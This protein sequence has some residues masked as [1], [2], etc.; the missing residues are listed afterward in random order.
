MG[1][2]VNAFNVVY[3]VTTALMHEGKCI[4]YSFFDT[5]LKEIHHTNGFHCTIL[6]IYL[7]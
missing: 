4:G 2:V 1:H 3:T 6:S 5:V 7:T